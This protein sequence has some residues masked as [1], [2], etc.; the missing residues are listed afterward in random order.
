MQGDEIYHPFSGVVLMPLWVFVSAWYLI[1]EG[2]DDQQDEAARKVKE[3]EVFASSACR[4]LSRLKVSV[5]V[6]PAC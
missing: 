2:S 3:L 4:R 6:A 5:S 1:T